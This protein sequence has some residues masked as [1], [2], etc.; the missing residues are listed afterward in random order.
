MGI[1]IMLALMETLTDDGACVFVS[2]F[3][4]Q[5]NGPLTIAQLNTVSWF[6]TDGTRV[7]M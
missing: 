4:G 7:L 2:L 1:N 3:D 5:L 6:T